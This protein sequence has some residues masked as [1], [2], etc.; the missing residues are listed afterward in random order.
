MSHW[1]MYVRSFLCGPRD[2]VSLQVLKLED[3]L[4]STL[5]DVRS[6]ANTLSPINRLPPEILSLIPTFLHHKRNRRS[7]IRWSQVCRHWR[8]VLIATPALWTHFSCKDLSRT[9]AFIERSKSMPLRVRL[10]PQFCLQ[11][12]K[13][14]IPHVK[15]FDS[16]RMELPASELFDK[17]TPNLRKPAPL[18]EQLLVTVQDT[19]HTDDDR[20]PPFPLLFG[21]KFPR[22]TRLT[23]EYV[24]PHP[25]WFNVSNLTIFQLVHT[26]SRGGSSSQLLRFFEQNP[27]LE[28]V[29][30]TY[31]GQFVDNAP[32]HHIV[33]L[34]C[35]R[36]LRL[37]DCP[38]KPGILHHLLLPPGVEVALRPFIPTHVIGI[39]SELPLR[40]RNPPSFLTGIDRI[41]FAEGSQASVHFAGPYGTLYIRA[42]GTTADNDLHDLASRCI[43]SFEPLDV[44]GVRELLIENYSPTRR[45]SLESVQ[46]SGIHSCLRSLPKLHTLILVSCANATHFQ[47]LQ[48]FDPDKDGIVC[49]ELKHLFIDVSNSRRPE[50][51]F[52]HFPF[53]DLLSLAET[54]ASLGIPLDRITVKSVHP[55]FEDRDLASLLQFVATVDTI[56]D[57]RSSPSWDSRDWVN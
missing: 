47:A 11:S 43:Y 18:L 13:A 9:H 54:R 55:L 8:N 26:G 23:L 57:D 24:S 42:S 15:R 27:E 22:L 14:L 20:E 48:T 35:L 52:P 41:S 16:L 12:F 4:H 44:S 37:G 6:W 56:G 40:M 49:P 7:L 46:D 31:Q 36:K 5:L 29:S 32:P 19:D 3:A 50:M 39:A 30:I 33:H 25:T 2:S 28:E 34:P 53:L 17:S 51:A 10:S 45:R 38:S 1:R 21:G